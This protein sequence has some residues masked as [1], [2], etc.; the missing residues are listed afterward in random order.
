MEVIIVFIV[1]FFAHYFLTQRI[2]SNNYF[3]FSLLIAGAIPALSYFFLQGQKGLIITILA[4]AFP[5]YIVILW[6]IKKL[7]RNLNHFLIRH[8]LVSLVFKNK[9]FTYIMHNIAT[10]DATASQ[11]K[12]ID[13]SWLDDFLSVA[14]FTFPLI[15]TALFI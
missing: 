12:I 10:V 3:L 5:L 1:Y 9:E 15:L 14:L 6:L 8:N 13:P 11:K 4:I 7:Y 2:Y